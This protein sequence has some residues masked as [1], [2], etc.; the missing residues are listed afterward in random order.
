M[1]CNTG[2]KSELLGTDADS[3]YTTQS[4]MNDNEGEGHMHM[5]MKRSRPEYFTTVVLEKLLLYSKGRNYKGDV[6]K[7]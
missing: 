7:A 5:C 2:W 3:V 6:G 1:Y 4:S